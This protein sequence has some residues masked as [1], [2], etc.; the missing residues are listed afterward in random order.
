MESR[1]RSATYKVRY[2]GPPNGPVGYGGNGFVWPGVDGIKDLSWIVGESMLRKQA[3]QAGSSVAAV[4]Y[5][6]IAV[7]PVLNVST[8]L[9]LNPAVTL[10]IWLLLSCSG[11]AVAKVAKNGNTAIP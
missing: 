9:N 2:Y 10:S 7:E 3:G 4:G 6:A 11:S 1:T 5:T 8:S